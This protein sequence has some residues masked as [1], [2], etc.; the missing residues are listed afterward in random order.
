MYPRDPVDIE[1]IPPLQDSYSYHSEPH[2]CAD[3]EEWIMGIDEAGRGRES[4]G[5][6]FQTSADTHS[7][8]G[9]VLV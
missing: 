8:T 5:L 2:Q 9:Y 7:C 1:P 6:K 4:T 3:G